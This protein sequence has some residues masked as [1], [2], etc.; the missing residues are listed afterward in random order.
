MINITALVLFGFGTITL[1][2]DSSLPPA[3]KKTNV[4][5]AADIKPIF[6][7][8]CVKCHS[9]DKPKAGLRLDS[10]EHALKGSKDGEV[11]VVGD[12]AKSL[13]VQSAAHTADDHDIW[14]PPAHN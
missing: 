14:M 5:Y 10:L 11:I 3:S 13:I 4:I 12:S 1:A 6:D 7:A 9:G 8:S 2:D